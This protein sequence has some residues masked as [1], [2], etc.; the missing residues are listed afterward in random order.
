MLG[1]YEHAG[2]P[3]FHCRVSECSFPA[4]PYLSICGGCVDVTSQVKQ[5]CYDS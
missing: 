2:S 3:T 5:T 1:L 4:F